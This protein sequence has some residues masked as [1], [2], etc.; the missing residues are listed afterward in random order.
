MSPRR[1]ATLLATIACLIT[2]SAALPGHAGAAPLK[3]CTRSHGTIV[4]VDFAHWG[5][6]IVRGCGID[7]K[8]GYDLL[9]VAGF[10]TAGDDHDGPAFICRL[11]DSAF[12]HGTQ[13][14][15]PKQDNCIL[16]PP[17]SAYWSYWL[18]AKG[19]NHWSYSQLG[20]MSE[21]PK[22]GEVEL[23]IF[24]GTNI[25]GTKGSGVPNFSPAS[26]RPP[27]HRMA[28][29][30]TATSSTTS[31]TST[32]TTSART[33]STT[34]TTTTHPASTTTTSTS[35]ATP[36]STTTSTPTTSTTT[37]AATP[38]AHRRHHHHHRRLA[39]HRSRVA[40]P[41]KTTS[42][43]T[44]TSSSDAGTT[45][46]VA[47]RPTSQRT[48]PGSA[49]PLIIGGALALLLAAGAGRAIWQRRRQ[50]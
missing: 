11:G 1:A 38:I 16:T 22:P 30:H 41:A 47:A 26:L 33:S 6:P 2:C 9:H 24:G 13:Y 3:Q 37:T 31:T 43:T 12:H 21:V 28:T 27:V 32:T 7:Q 48:S 39:H 50:E 15:T 8:S 49:T 29:T 19:Q 36:A 18:A 44:T 10:T 5:G 25:A 35:S 17:A 20:A 23:W 40:I 46:V 4:A 14:P 45:P 34:R 42:S